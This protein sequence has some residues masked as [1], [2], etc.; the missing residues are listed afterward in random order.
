[1]NIFAR[2]TIFL[3]FLQVS[4]STPLF[5]LGEFLDTLHPNEYFLSIRRN[6][7]RTVG[8]KIS[9]TTLEAF[10]FPLDYK[11]VWPFLDFRAHRFDSRDKYAAN[12]GLGCRFAPKFTDQVFGMNVYYD[13]RN[14]HCNSF[15]QI[16]LGFEMLGKCWNCRLNGYLPIGKKQVLDST[17]F[18]DSFIGSY[19]MF[20]KNYVRALPGLDFELESYL[21]SIC[22]VDVYVGMEAYY[23]KGDR[24]RGN[25]YG[26]E[27]RLTTW[28]CDYLSFSIG[29]TH[30][31]IFKTRVQGIL[32]LT[33]P[34]KCFCGTDKRL[35]Y[36]VRRREIIV[37][38]RHS[39]WQ[40]NW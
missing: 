38:D 8:N 32:S 19:Y 12:L 33:Y 1:M 10:S 30:D 40:W 20:R 4:L 17:C 39:E 3:F 28:Y 6:Q 34:F 26:A 23:Y 2:L 37:L 16:G 29:V 21:A 18:F 31:C 22:C 24:C 36:S 9:Y 13:T 5:S 11:S 7:G 35:F 15:E 27:Y 14:A 25:V